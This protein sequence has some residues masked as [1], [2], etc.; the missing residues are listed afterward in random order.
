MKCQ[1]AVLCAAESQLAGAESEHAVYASTL[2]LTFA[3]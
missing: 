3:S 2:T 1:H